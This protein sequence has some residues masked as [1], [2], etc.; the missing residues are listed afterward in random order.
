MVPWR[1]QRH[2]AEKVRPVAS[3][4]GLAALAAQQEQRDR[5]RGKG[6]DVTRDQETNPPI[7][8]EAIPCPSPPADEAFHGLAGEI[9]Q[10]VSPYTE[11]DNAAL[12]ASI[13]PGVGNLV[14]GGPH[15]MAGEDKH[16]LK[17]NAVLVG[18]SSKGRKGS[19]L[20]P[21]QAIFRIVD[22]AYTDWK[23]IPGGLSTGEVLIWQMRDPII[24]KQPVK[25]KGRVV[26]YEML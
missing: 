13:L 19:S 23:I 25:D 11:A 26:D 22:Q 5:T 21:I 7:E 16:Q 14:G 10:E 20:S 1:G 9:V 2:G 18:E 24:Q 6:T 8:E 4:D 17:L 15:F 12:L 3:L